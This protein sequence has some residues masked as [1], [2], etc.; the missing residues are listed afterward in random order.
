MRFASG[1]DPV[2]AMVHA[3]R[4]LVL[5]AMDKGWSG[6]SFDPFKLA[7]IRGIGI[8]PRAD[9]LDARTVSAGQ[10]R[11]L[12]EYNPTRP[13]GRLRYSIA[14]DIAHTLFPDCGERIRNRARTSAAKDDWQL[15]ALCNIAA[16][17]ILMPIGSMKKEQ[18]EILSI[19]TMKL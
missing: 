18:T 9:I 7:E 10:N 14:H 6:P 13:I 19:L 17:E 12:I 2:R 3:A 16:A 1:R 5:A 8:S 4:E 15:E 11:F